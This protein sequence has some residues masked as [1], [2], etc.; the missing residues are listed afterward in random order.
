MPLMKGVALSVTLV[1]GFTFLTAKSFTGK[2]LVKVAANL[3]H[4][5]YYFFQPPTIVL[6]CV[7]HYVIL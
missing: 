6:K 1:M 2:T 7:L 4:Q 3:W 5:W